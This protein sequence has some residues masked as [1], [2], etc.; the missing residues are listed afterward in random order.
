VGRMAALGWKATTS[1]EEGI[2]RAY[3]DFLA[4]GA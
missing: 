2:A 3:A 1:L 4:R